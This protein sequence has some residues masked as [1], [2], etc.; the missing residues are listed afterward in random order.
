V[1]QGLGAW[2]AA[3]QQEEGQGGR[4]GAGGAEAGSQER[5]SSLG[6]PDCRAEGTSLGMG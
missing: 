3:C 4:E 5:E 2:D 6:S 1:T